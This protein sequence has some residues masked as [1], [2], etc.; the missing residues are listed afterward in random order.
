[1]CVCVCVCVCVFVKWEMEG[2]RK[3]TPIPSFVRWGNRLSMSVIGL[4]TK[5]T[6]VTLISYVKIRIIWNMY[7]RIH[8]AFFKRRGGTTRRVPGVARCC[9]HEGENLTE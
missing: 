4:K 6:I 1:M 7:F 9:L 2:E 8:A 3:M 5:I